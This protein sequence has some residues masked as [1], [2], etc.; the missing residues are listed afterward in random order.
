M[1]AQSKKKLNILRYLYLSISVLINA[2]II[3]Q[4]ILPS[5][6]SSNWSNA[7]VSFFAKIFHSYSAPAEIVDA[8]KI[9][10]VFNDAYKFNDV[11]E[12]EKNEIVVDKDKLLRVTFFPVDT[13]NKAMV[14]TSSNPDVA[15]VAIEGSLIR[16]TGNKVGNTI[17]KVASE[18]NPSIYSEMAFSVV[19]RKAPQAYTVR[20]I[21]VFKD[22]IFTAPITVKDEDYLSYYNLDDLEVTYDKRYFVRYNEE[23]YQ[24]IYPGEGI[25]KVEGKEAKVKIKDNSSLVYPTLLSIVGKDIFSSYQSYQYTVSNKLD[26]TYKYIWEA[27]S[28]LITVDENGKVTAGFIEEETVVNITA[29]LVLDPVI[30]ATKKLYLYPTKIV[31]IYLQ[32]MNNGDTV[33]NSYYLADVRQQL[34]VKLL[35][36]SGTAYMFGVD[37]KSGNSDVAKAYSQ[38]EYIYIDCLKE[39]RTRIDVASMNNPEASAYIDLEVINNGAI[40]NGNY[41]SFSSFIRK[42]IGHFLLFAVNGVFS[43]L[44]IYYFM[45][46]ME[47]AKKWLI[48]T[49]ALCL[50]LCLASISELIQFFVPSRSGSVLDVLVDFG[51]FI[52]GAIVTYL[53][54]YLID[55]RKNNI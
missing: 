22:Q 10:L 30:S 13:T 35:D 6:M 29:R 19:K 46:D 17:V 11:P 15:S 20:S 4:S 47:G 2:F 26:D 52:L 25:F 33:T 38:G 40:N 27:D 41:Q 49:V 42:S 53:I 1:E 8:T 37:L 14:A 18:T 44:F 45:K 16:V 3:A 12:Y 5:N 34:K 9:D 23:Y 48:I 21:E 54:I 39:G 50:G 55:K 32:E 36:Y 7:F 43:F 51:G 28:K 31:E 24:A